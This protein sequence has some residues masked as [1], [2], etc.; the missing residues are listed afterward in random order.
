[1]DN[2]QAQV[3][4]QSVE[5]A[6]TPAPDLNINDLTNLR[7][8]VDTAVRR[9]AFGASEMTAVGA[10][11]DRLNNFLNAIAATQQQQQ[12]TADGQQTVGSTQ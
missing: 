6:S 11:F 5:G 4:G 2:S 7:S 8:V 12:A 9:G 1:M 10:V 3:P